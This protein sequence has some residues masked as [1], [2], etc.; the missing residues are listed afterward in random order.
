MSISICMIVKNE[1]E[2]L[3][4]ALD[5]WTSWADELLIVDTGSTDR[6]VELANAHGAKV[7]HYEW[8]APGHKGEAR[9]VGLDAARGDWIVVLDADEVIKDGARLREVIAQMRPEIDGINVKFA[10][11]EG[12]KIT[13]E[14][15]QM[16]VFRRGC[17]RY[18]HREHEIP[19]PSNKPGDLL[20]LD[21]T[22]E[23]RPPSARGPIKIEPM[24]ARL[25]LDVV[26]H[27][28][29]P[30]SLYM[31]ARQYALAG[32]HDEAKAHC[33]MYLHLPYA[34]LKSEAC[35]VAA[36]SALQSNNRAT[37]YEWFHRATAYEPQRRL[38]WVDL[39]NL[40]YGDKQYMMALALARMA[41]D[42]PLSPFQRETQPQEQLTYICQLIEACRY[43][44]AHE[45]SH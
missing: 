4:R 28:G 42:L 39:A 36:I 21:V 35:R 20:Y 17:Y 45:H 38:L 6:T 3:G 9:N 32:C 37:A 44:L 31:L 18:I 16:R 12:E 25:K 30:H 14:W 8:V 7:L 43:S 10:N 40:Y 23:H 27:P 11:V 5:G 41:A 29:D 33:E 26:E 24:L 13:L 22:F 2:V 19:T 34:G 15:Y 1:A